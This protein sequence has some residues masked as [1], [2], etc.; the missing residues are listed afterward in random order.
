MLM[1]TRRDLRLTVPCEIK[2]SGYQ[3]LGEGS[4]LNLSTG[5]WQ[6]RSRQALPEGTPLFLRVYL[7]DGEDPI[8]IELATVQW[9]YEGK[10]GLKTVIMGDEARKRL[11]R[12]LRNHSSSVASSSPSTTPLPKEDA[13]KQAS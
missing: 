1:E 10:F 3:L 4:V 9:S 12:F 6:V 11:R 7:P 2:Y 5:G 8:D 13:F